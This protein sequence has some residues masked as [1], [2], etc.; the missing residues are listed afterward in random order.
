MKTVIG[1]VGAERVVI[2]DTARVRVR[3]TAVGCLAEEVMGFSHPSIHPSMCLMR[4]LCMGL[5]PPPPA[6]RATALLLTTR[7]LV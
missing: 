7:L 3:V 5:S 1:V 4:R 2:A 6:C